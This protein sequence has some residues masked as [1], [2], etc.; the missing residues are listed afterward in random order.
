VKALVI[1]PAYN[2]EANLSFVLKDLQGFAGDLLVV[3]DGSTDATEEV[4]R[5]L[6]AS[7]VS[8]PFN[9]GIGGSV[10]TG[11]KYALRN[12]YDYAIQ[13]DGDGQHRADQIGKIIVA[14][15]AGKADLVIGARTLPEGYKCGFSRKIGSLIFCL[16]IRILTGKRIADPTAG[17]RCYGPNA[18]RL[19]SLSYPDDYPEV[20]SIITASRNGLIIAEVPVVMRQRMSGHS[21]INRRKSAY[22]M[23]KVTLAMLVDAMRG[24]IAWKDV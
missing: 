21:S 7:F 9:L 12:G 18:L 16:L 13:F 5:S 14:V 11:L 20:E 1:I 19:F 8:H 17:F 4:A 23:L 6:G 2:E 10:Q 22:Y 15:E 24:Q 3:N